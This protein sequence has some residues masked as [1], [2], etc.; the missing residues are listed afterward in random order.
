MKPLD[1][2][3]LGC[4]AWLAML[5]PFHVAPPLWIALLAAPPR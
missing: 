1:V 5:S 4:A 3:A 2:M